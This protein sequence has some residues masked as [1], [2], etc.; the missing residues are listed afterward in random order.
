MRLN[1]KAQAGSFS[2]FSFMV[3]AFLAVLVFASLIYTMGLINDVFVNVGI[4]NEALP[5]PVYQ[6][7]CIS[8]QSQT[9][10]VSTYVNMS[11]ASEQ[12]FGQLNQSI[13]ALRLV[14]LVYILG[15]AAILIIT[16]SLVRTNPIWF[17]AVLLISL[18]AIL[19]APT[20]SNAYDTVLQANIFNGELQ[21]WTAVNWIM[22]NLPVVVLV[23]SIFMGIFSLINL[24]RG[25]SGEGE[26]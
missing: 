18:L 15:L 21:N 3:F 8:N 17:F 11:S 10:N 16:G 1:K 2:V 12:I 7:P 22:L 25:V 23:I 9:C 13:Q 20:I 26:L 19:F 24:I 6:I 4:A 14:G 5:H